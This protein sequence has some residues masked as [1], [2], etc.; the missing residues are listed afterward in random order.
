MQET[1]C[2]LL[3]AATAVAAQSST[4][5][6]WAGVWQGELDGQPSV[7]LTL[8]QDNGIL[9]GTLVL[10]IISRDNG[11]PRVIAHEPHTLMQLHVD[12]ARLSFRLKRIDG[13]VTP[14]AFNVALTSP[15][16]AT[17]HC[18]NCGDGAPTVEIAK[19][20]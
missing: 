9:E 14:M 16:H 6:D 1:L 7:V 2:A 13:S 5:F 3:I 4:A 17:I 8:A 19:Q 18:L 15:D 10:N 12:G 11:Q 20:D